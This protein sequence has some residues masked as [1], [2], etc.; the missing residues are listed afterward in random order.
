MNPGSSGAYF[1]DVPRGLP[2]R[3]PFDPFRD[4]L[5]AEDALELIGCSS[6]IV[7]HALTIFASSAARL[8]TSAASLKRMKRALGWLPSK[9]GNL[10]GIRAPRLNITF[11]SG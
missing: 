6:I 7:H 2:L 5:L 1:L 4:R 3:A 10:P 8:S 9:C 11:T